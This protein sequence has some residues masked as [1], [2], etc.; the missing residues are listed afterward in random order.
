[1]IIL[2]MEL[3][4][5]AFTITDTPL[6]ALARLRVLPGPRFSLYYTLH[7][8]DRALTAYAVSFIDTLFRKSK[9]FR[10][11]KDYFINNFLFLLLFIVV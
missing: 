5:F 11:K 1:M 6:S 10:T 2:V 9:P 3:A 4:P 7:M 8:R